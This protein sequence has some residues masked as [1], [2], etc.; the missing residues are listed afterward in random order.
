[1]HPTAMNDAQA[2]QYMQRLEQKL[3]EGSLTPREALTRAFALGAETER[4]DAMH[5]ACAEY[6]RARTHREAAFRGDSV[7]P[8]ARR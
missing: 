5:H 1:M 8:P 7:P 6:S 4:M 2:Q 3:A